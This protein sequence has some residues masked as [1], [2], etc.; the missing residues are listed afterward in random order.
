MDM[1]KNNGFDKS[2]EASDKNIPHTPEEDVVSLIYHLVDAATGR[3]LLLL[4]NT[5]G[6]IPP[7]KRGCYQCCNQHIL[8]NR[9]EAH[10]LGQF[11]RRQ[12]S[13]EETN[14]L[15]LRTRQWHNWNDN[16][17][18]KNSLPGINQP[19]IFSGGRPFCPLLVKGSCS[20][21]PM[22]PISCRTHFVCSDPAFCRFSDNPS[23]AKPKPIALTSVVTATN[24]FSKRLK[25]SINENASDFSHGTMLLP[26]WLA[27]EM[28]WAF[29]ISA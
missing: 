8:I 21:Y 4:R 27:I 14:R 16:R 15:M 25:K 6:I 28:G 11:I 3:E 24:L 26:H 13:T 9:S 17:P 20:A 7:C 10:A 5:K 2:I 12:F 1:V 22:R 23:A 18:G 29:A 19:A